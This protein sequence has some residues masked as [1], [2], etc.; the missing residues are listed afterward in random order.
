MGSRSSL[1]M[2]TELGIGG[3]ACFPGERFD[4]FARRLG[5]LNCDR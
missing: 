5:R 1:T 2:P 3:D 4:P